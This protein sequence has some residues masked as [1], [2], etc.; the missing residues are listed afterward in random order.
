MSKV[1]VIN[2]LEQANQLESKIIESCETTK[3]SIITLISESSGAELLHSLKFYQSGKDPLKER[4]LNFIEQLNQTFTY[5]V[6]IR[7]TK[8]LLSDFPQFTPYT[9]NLG[10]QSGYDIV[11]R[12]GEIIAETFAATS[13]TSNN[14]L[15]KD[16]VRVN[17][18]DGSSH[19]FVFFYSP[20]KYSKLENMKLKYPD[21][22]I[23]PI[24]IAF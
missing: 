21:V 17:S 7:A 12:N 3:K 19:K 15:S 5:L 23:V 1:V 2:S 13:P 4:P 18:D 9:L 8:Y 6:S 24:D 20:S 11:S 16:V 14:K 10:T 22:T